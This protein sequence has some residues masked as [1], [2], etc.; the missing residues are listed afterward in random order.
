MEMGMN[1]WSLENVSFNADMGRAQFQR[2]IADMIERRGRKIGTK[3]D[4]EINT[5]SPAQSPEQGNAVPV[6]ASTK[7]R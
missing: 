2:M 6:V 7:I 3:V 1:P 5:P 4:I